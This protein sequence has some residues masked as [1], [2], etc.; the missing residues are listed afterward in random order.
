MTLLKSDIKSA[1]E[2]FKKANKENNRAKSLYAGQRSNLYELIRQDNLAKRDVKASR[3]RYNKKSINNLPSFVAP[4][5]FEGHSAL[6]S[7]WEC[8]MTKLK[9]S[10]ITAIG[11]N[12]NSRV[13]KLILNDVYVYAYQDIPESAYNIFLN[14][15]SPGRYFNRFK[16]TYAGIR[17][18]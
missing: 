18:V 3:R 2:A 12:A 17:L 9:S 1:V 7:L 11:Y 8:K 15:S 4:L 16:Q 6:P 5:A 14:S 13:L 10:Y